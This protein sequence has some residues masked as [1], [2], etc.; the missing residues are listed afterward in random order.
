MNAILYQCLDALTSIHN[1]DITHRDLKPENILVQAR[2][3]LHIKLADFGISKAT[4]D[5]AT[6]TGTPLYMAPELWTT[7]K[8]D[9]YTNACDIWSLG[10]VIFQY[11]YGPLLDSETREGLK[12]CKEIVSH[13]RSLASHG[14]LDHLRNTMLIIDS[15]RRL[16]ASECWKRSMLLVQAEDYSPA[17]VSALSL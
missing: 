10:V 7:H 13:A 12:W 4:R 15:S 6:R 17:V 11:A 3:P 1:L 16:S 8:T 9:F 5:L 2:D 14:L